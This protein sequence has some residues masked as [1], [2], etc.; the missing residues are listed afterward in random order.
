MSTN[1]ALPWWFGPA[2]R[3]NT[4]LLR[5]GFRIGT[6][7]VLSVSGRTSGRLRST[8]VSVVTL[9][10]IRYIVSGEGLAWLKNARAAGWGTLLRAGHREGS[11]SPSCRPRSEDQSCGRSG[12]RCRAV[13]LSSP[14]S[15]ASRPTP[16]PTTS[17]RPRRVALSFAS[18]D[19]PDDPARPWPI[20]HRCPRGA[21]NGLRVS[22]RWPDR[23][24]PDGLTGRRTAR[25]S[26]GDRPRRAPI[27]GGPRLLAEGRGSREHQQSARRRSWPGPHR[28]APTGSAAPR[29]PRGQPC[30]HGGRSRRRRWRARP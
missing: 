30:R 18:A 6:Q 15:S 24:P 17:R 2:S 21:D 13:V 8:P 20:A 14:A 19:P 29:S 12:T 11:R 4:L 22:A 28:R 1:E 23:G 25:A 10:Q 27:S 16:A 3:L 9:D 26:H 7:H 5:L